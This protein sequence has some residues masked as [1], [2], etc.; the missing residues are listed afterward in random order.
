MHVGAV[1]LDV[2]VLG[3]GVRFYLHMAVTCGCMVYG[4]S[5]IGI[6]MR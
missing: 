2:E 3:G 6:S 4:C 5:G 1:F